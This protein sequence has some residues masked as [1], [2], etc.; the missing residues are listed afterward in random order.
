M[1]QNNIGVSVGTNQI[2]AFDF[3]Q[4]VD[5]RMSRGR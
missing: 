4:V 2:S 5:N 1:N 3:W